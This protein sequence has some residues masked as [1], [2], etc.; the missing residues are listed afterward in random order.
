MT[1]QP[2][3]FTCL[4]TALAMLVNDDPARVIE[5][6]NNDGTRVVDGIHMAPHPQEITDAAWGLYMM[7]LTFIQRVL[8]FSLNSVYYEVLSPEACHMRLEGYLEYDSIIISEDRAHAWAYK[9]GKLLCPTAGKEV[10]MIDICIIDSLL[11]YLR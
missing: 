9:N 3:K 7:P 1:K 6:I 2:N 5:Y 4:P 10:P 8:R 11:V